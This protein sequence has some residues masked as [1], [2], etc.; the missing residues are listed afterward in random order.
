[1]I[2]IYMANNRY[3]VKKSQCAE[4]GDGS[5]IIRFA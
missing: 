5:G 4:C 3:V 2:F 1:M